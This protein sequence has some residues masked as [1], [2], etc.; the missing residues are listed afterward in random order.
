MGLIIHRRVSFLFS[1]SSLSFFSF[2]LLFV[3]DGP[4]VFTRT[5]RLWG[6][7]VSCEVFS[8]TAMDTKR[9]GG[10]VQLEGWKLSERGGVRRVTFEWCS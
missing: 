9:Q 6:R 8:S 7:A 10:A 3:V 5:A 1:L 2:F 4:G